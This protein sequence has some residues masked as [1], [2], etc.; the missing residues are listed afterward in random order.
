MPRPETAGLVLDQADRSSGAPSTLPG[1]DLASPPRSPALE[2]VGRVETPRQETPRQ[3][4]P[5]AAAPPPRKSGLATR[6]LRGL[7]KGLATL[8]IA[9]VAVL[10]ALATWEDYVATPWT[11]DGRVRVQVASVAP[12]VSGEITE[13]RVGDNQY[14]RKGDVLYV[15][16]PID[17]EVTLRADKA[18]LQQKA[19]DLQVKQMQ[20]LR[21]QQLSTLATTPE[22]QQTFA[23][24]ALQAK[25]AFDAAQQQAAQA[26][27]DLRRTK[28]LSP[29]NGYVT[30]LTM[31]VGDYAHQGGVN[32]SIIDTD[33]FWI[34]GYFE[35]TKMARVCIGDR[36]EAKLLGYAQ[37]VLGHVASV[38]RGIGVSDA[39]A[40]TQGLPNVDPVYTWVR[41]AQRVP[42]HIAIDSV[43]PGVPLV[44]GMTATVT[45][46][47]AGH[48]EGGSWLE[49]TVSGFK[50][51]LADALHG[52]PARP[53]CIPAT[54]T[55]QANTMSLRVDNEVSAS[56][57]DQLNPGLAPSM[58][59]SPKDY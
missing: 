3:D 17:F 9:I 13:L 25:G 19:A 15:I 24:A 39:A 4:A 43:P 18:Q 34:D 8:A 29:V 45:V 41:L 22:E 51:R 2:T 32:I 53:G 57:P 35:E 1:G 54:T 11:R 40:G 55:E 46:E 38:S 59:A 5:I 56:A 10:M 42:V 20:S 52:P 23:G 37:P 21:R 48:A 58:A 14:V 44:S 30:N 12:Q 27:I 50:A 6:R 47:D 33:S 16:D 31:R 49:R 36:V 28:V 26:E 7:A